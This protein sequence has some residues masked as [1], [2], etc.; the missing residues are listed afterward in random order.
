MSSLRDKIKAKRQ[1]IADKNAG[2]ERPWKW[3]VGKT[4][5]RFVPGKET[6]E[7]FF[8]EIGIHWIKDEKG[9]FVTAVGDRQICFGEPC[10]V[11]EAIDRVI[12]TGRSQ[13]GKEGDALVELGKD[14]IAKS[15]YFAN[16][17]IISAPGDFEKDKATLV[18]F[19]EQVWDQILSQLYDQLE[20]LPEGTDLLKEGPLSLAKGVVFTLEKSGSGKTNTKYHASFSGKTAPIDVNLVNG[21]ID[22]AAYKR[23]QF[24]KNQRQALTVLGAMIGVDMSDIASALAAPAKSAGALPAPGAKD[25]GKWGDEEEVQDEGDEAD[26]PTVE[27][28]DDEEET[29]TSAAPSDDDILSQLDDL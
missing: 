17:K 19:P 18:E 25:A 10:P 28:E 5:F 1:A 29:A 15:R 8:E 21:A 9:K 27:V 23:A 13:G 6:A 22:L 14:M 24:G 16:I 26:G 2:H 12:Q 11:R 20:E 4:Y 7:A 3:P